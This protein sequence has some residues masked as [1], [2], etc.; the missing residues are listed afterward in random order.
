M[1]TLIAPILLVAGLIALDLLA[2]RFGVDSRDGRRE[3]W[4]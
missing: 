2:L 3:T 1:D 4:W